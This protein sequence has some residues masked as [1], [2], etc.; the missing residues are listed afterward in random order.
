MSTY[1][2]PSTPIPLD[3]I[4]NNNSLK[5]Q[6]FEVV[7]EDGE[8]YFYCDSYLHF[9]TDTK[10]NVIDLYRFN[11]NNADNVLEPLSIE[12]GV[13]F[14][15]EYEDEYYDLASPETPVMTIS[16]ESLAEQGHSPKMIESTLAEQGEED[17]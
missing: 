3:D 15:S 17:E 8:Q 11:S 16:W 10:N 7:Q 14:I 1:Y 5:L 2:R 4:K 12:F 13:D 6:G 9:D